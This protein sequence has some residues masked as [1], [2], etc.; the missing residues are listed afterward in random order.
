MTYRKPA[1]GPSHSHRISAHKILQKSVQQ[2][3]RHAH[4]QTHRHTN[5]S[6]ADQLIANSGNTSS[7]KAYH[8]SFSGSW[9]I[10]QT[11][12]HM[13]SQLTKY[14]R[15]V[16][17]WLLLETDCLND[18]PEQNAYFTLLPHQAF[19]YPPGS[20]M[21]YAVSHPSNIIRLA[22]HS[23]AQH[24]WL[25]FMKLSCSCHD[26]TQLMYIT[27]VNLAHWLA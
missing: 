11:H 26:N 8:K 21:W 18:W 20:I 25:D 16:R 19:Y 3:Q 2:F 12:S 5:D 27:T 1:R 9:T 6:K 4:R 24:Y 22:N 14:T 17:E 23:W 7:P 13:Q 10:P 15:K